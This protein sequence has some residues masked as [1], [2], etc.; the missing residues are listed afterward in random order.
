M[1]TKVPYMSTV[2]NLPNILDRIQQAGAPEVFNLDFLRD[3]GFKSSNDRGVIKVLKYLGMLDDAGKPQTSYRE[4]MNSAAAK[5]VLA[6]QLQSAYDELFLAKRTAHNDSPKMLKGWFQTKTGESE[7]VAT[8]IATTFRSLATYAD[9]EASSD[10][11]DHTADKTEQSDELSNRES[12]PKNVSSPG[13][14]NVPMALTYR[15]EIN[16]PNTTDVRVFRSIFR[17]LKSEL[18]S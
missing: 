13:Q 4:F 9:F 14:E 17:A 5:G 15:L 1:E 11:Q 6:K 3:L 2:K 8:K 7:A 12:T 10:I 18:L 16:L